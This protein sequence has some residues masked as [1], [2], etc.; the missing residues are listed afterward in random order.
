MNDPVS[1]KESA[2]KDSIAKAKVEVK[3]TLREAKDTI[4]SK[5]QEAVS[6]AKEC[7]QEYLQQGKERTAHRIG[8]VS[9]SVR[10][11]ADRFDQEQDPNIAHY[12]RLLADKLQ[13]AA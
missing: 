2:T 6:Q 3:T 5:T 4:K 9:E 8:E 13:S 12:T 11:T 1:S 10:K 7:G